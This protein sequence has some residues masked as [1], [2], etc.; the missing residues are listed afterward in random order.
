MTTRKIPKLTKAQLKKR[1]QRN[2]EKK[3]QTELALPK[4]P[5]IS[6][7]LY[8]SLTKYR[9]G[10]ECGLVLE[11]AYVNGKWFPST[12]A[13]EL[14]NY[15]EYICTGSLP[16]DGHIPEAKLVYKGKPNEKM[17]TDYARMHKQ[18]ENFD[19]IMVE[20]GFTIEHTGFAFTNNKFSGIADIIAKD[21]DGNRVIIDV[22]SSGLI[23]DKWT[24]YGWAD[25]SIELK[26]E[27]MIQAIHYKML[28]QWEWQKD[29]VPFY[30]MVFSTKND[31]DCKVF[32]IIVEESRFASHYAQLLG[33]KN[34]LHE[35]IQRGWN[36]KP[37]MKRCASCP[38]AQ[39]R[40]C[41]F[42]VD[43]PKLQKVYI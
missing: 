19:R 11:E 25:E 31:V 8:K 16:R 15:F 21:V 5:K 20:M 38:L 37:E 7:S 6:Q 39:D 33:A 18:K 2:E 12:P 13:Q 22:K 23:N 17:A 35:T 9:N 4:I 36:A 3:K 28:A 26:D 1:E 24:D 30:F 32:E 34:F 29:D 10:L 40:T 43:T 41:I 14:G 42:S 27:L